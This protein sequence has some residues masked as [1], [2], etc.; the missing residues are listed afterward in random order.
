MTNTIKETSNFKLIIGCSTHH[1][2]APNLLLY[3]IVN[4]EYGV[5]EMETSV[6]ARALLAI[7]GV[8]GE[9]DEVLNP[10][11]TPAIVMED[12]SGIVGKAIN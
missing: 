8:Q 11:P 5:V 4:K 1:T 7:D 3:Q 2:D 9:L 10:T 6:L 12:M